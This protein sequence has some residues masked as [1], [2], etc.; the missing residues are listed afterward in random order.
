MTSFAELIRLDDESRRAVIDSMSA[1]AVRNMIRPESPFGLVPEDVAA[2]LVQV[3]AGRV[4]FEKQF[5]A[6][7][8]AFMEQEGFLEPEFLAPTAQA[9]P[10]ATPVLTGLGE[11]LQNIAQSGA[12]IVG[13]FADSLTKI[14]TSPDTAPAMFSE[15]DPSYVDDFVKEEFEKSADA[16]GRG[17]AG[18]F[19]QHTFGALAGGTGRIW[20]KLVAEGQVWMGKGIAAWTLHEMAGHENLISDLSRKNMEAVVGLSKDG[21]E[22]LTVGD[23]KLARELFKDAS[24][25]WPVAT[26]GLAEGM[27]AL[28]LDLMIPAPKIPFGATFRALERVPIAGAAARAA[29]RRVD[30]I[31]DLPTDQKV[32]RFGQNAERVLGHYYNTAASTVGEDEVARAIRVV[33]DL[34]NDKVPLKEALP[35]YLKRNPE[36]GT[37]QMLQ[38]TRE[39]RDHMGRIS[40]APYREVPIDGSQWSRTHVLQDAADHI[41]TDYAKSVGF[42]G[43]TPGE[44]GIARWASAQ[45][46][47]Q[48]GYAWLVM[49]MPGFAI[50][51]L[52]GGH[53]TIGMR[54]GARKV[55]GVFGSMKWADRA[56][57]GLGDS[58]ILY[59]TRARESGGMVARHIIGQDIRGLPKP[60]LS[61]LPVVGD[62]LLPLN[63]MS[64]GLRDQ[65]PKWIKDVPGLGGIGRKLI[66]GVESRQHKLVQQMELREA[67][68]HAFE[69]LVRK[70]TLPK[71][72]QDR[73]INKWWRGED[74]FDDNRTRELFSEMV[75]DF[76]DFRP[77][78]DNPLDALPRMHNS[79]SRE[80]VEGEVG[81]L[82]GLGRR[83]TDDEL[84]EAFERAAVRAEQDGIDAARNYY[85]EFPGEVGHQANEMLRAFRDE[86]VTPDK[87]TYEILGRALQHDLEVTVAERRVLDAIGVSMKSLD[88]PEGQ[89]RLL[90]EAM[91]QVE[92]RFDTI[93]K[94]RGQDIAKLSAR[95]VKDREVDALEAGR[96][97]ME[98]HND[99]IQTYA[100]R[101]GSV[102]DE[103]YVN[104]LQKRWRA[105]LKALPANIR[106]TLPGRLDESARARV[107]AARAALKR[108]DNNLRRVNA[109]FAKAA[110]AAR[111]K[112]VAARDRDLAALNRKRVE[113]TVAAYNDAAS[114]AGVELS[115]ATLR[116]PID[117]DE[118]VRILRQV[119]AER[120]DDALAPLL[121]QSFG[122]S[123]RNSGK[124]QAE[125]IRRATDAASANWNERVS[126][127][128]GL[129]DTADDVMKWRRQALTIGKDQAEKVSNEALF[130]YLYNR[131][132]TFLQTLF[133]YPY[134]GMK[135]A[136]MT[137]RHIMKKPGQ[138]HAFVWMMAEWLK[139]TEDLPWYLTWTVRVL[140][141]PDGSEV[142]FDP[143]T[144]VLPFG[145]NIAEIIN[146]G[147]EGE[148]GSNL[149]SMLFALNLWGISSVYPHYSLLME[150]ARKAMG[151]EKFE[152]LPPEVK[153]E[154]LGPFGMIPPME[155][156]M[157][158]LGGAHQRLLKQAAGAGNIPF[159]DPTIIYNNGLTSR[160][161]SVVGYVLAEM[162]EAGE[163]T[164]E[165]AMQ[166]SVD[167]RT[168]TFNPAAFEA[169]Q[170]YLERK[171]RFTGINILLGGFRDYPAAR[172]Q[173]DAVREQYRKLLDAGDREGA[174][175]LI[176][177][178]P[179]LPVRW[180]VWDDI[181]EAQK[182]VDEAKFWAEYDRVYGELNSE[183]GQLDV[184]D[185]AAREAMQAE[186]RERIDAASE[187]FGVDFET[188][189][190]RELKFADRARVVKDLVRSFRETIRAED[191]LDKDGVLLGE[192][193]GD[194]REQW[195]A[196][197]I[198]ATMQEEFQAELTKN[199]SLS[200]AILDTYQDVYLSGYFENTDGMEREEREEWIALNPPPSAL[201]LARAVQEAFPR[202]ELAD[203]H[204]KIEADNLSIEGYFDAS[205]Q[206]K[207]E[208]VRRSTSDAPYAFRSSGGRVVNRDNLPEYIEAYQQFSRWVDDSPRREHFSEQIERLNA[209]FSRSM[210][211]LSVREHLAG[212]GKPI[213]ARYHGDQAAGTM[214][215]VDLAHMQRE[216]ADLA[217]WTETVVKYY[218]SPQD[219][220][221][222]RED[223]LREIRRAY[224]AVN[225]TGF[226]TDD[227]S[228]AWR[229]FFAARETQLDNVMALPEAQ[230]MGINRRMFMQWLHKD[231]PPT[232]AVS[233]Y[234]YEASIRP[235]LDERAQI[236]EASGGRISRRQHDSLA[237]RYRARPTVREKVDE[238]LGA[239][240]HLTRAQL[241]PLLDEVLPSFAEYWELRGWS[242]PAVQRERSAL[243][244]VGG[245]GRRN[246]FAP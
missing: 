197:N 139:Q 10:E 68:S 79:I 229:E 198:P 87:R 146:A 136:T 21:L 46:K 188:D 202:F 205:T 72:L 209:E 215:L 62:S 222:L 33:E 196:H 109:D 25:G 168:V 91:D 29:R 18:G 71:N 143:K 106:K 101:F 225:P 43:A 57:E 4:A 35:E 231:S 178:H 173:A 207:I 61:Y 54:M 58:A 104:T 237:Y 174:N 8:L 160:E 69:T 36:L 77:A 210:A 17:D 30:W 131:G 194:A 5:G 195:R 118:Y 179:G 153:E 14:T 98:G 167:I 40:M 157:A 42:R 159:V 246:P 85:K 123:L 190:G 162:A 56:A 213:V 150:G 243:A 182:Q 224:Y 7:G 135:F 22:R 151:D 53:M 220:D 27:F 163:I 245:G 45:V 76:G 238:I 137:A 239:M 105:E 124:R 60:L 75:I 108:V 116:F 129:T 227:G 66:T 32:T 9:L 83:A 48:L 65:L 86:G 240:P 191:F 181:E 74:L 122:E 201:V 127:I 37:K 81:A 189:P 208:R 3:G 158:S 107:I 244:A 112:T 88:I 233:Q 23:T 70:S 115:E 28:P 38:M 165:V 218:T 99:L 51:N 138:F 185:M 102:A 120:G 34:A 180:I 133:P 132:E 172:R 20:E 235:A 212:Q 26:A 141:M 155:D 96:V 111:R 103:L 50:M 145:G 199:V 44:L 161:R 113:D 175:A 184:T 169:M 221:E 200:E 142:R 121:E 12:P 11:G 31:K 90:Q 223:A 49:R 63:L 59:G 94:G 80:M 52:L 226:V 16:L 164:P 130:S 230:K 214:G 15:P 1:Q 73:L 128:E 186:A 134:W 187:K 232:E 2:F 95:Y 206:A 156:A 39:T 125:S 64:K 6:K 193:Y 82:A 93:R 171:A 166:A 217:P 236:K 13:G 114:T 204:A 92:F 47:N 149:R 183:L 41:T 100:E 147:E 211:A 144:M 67:S 241:E 19:F 154:L 89:K 140:K 219:S 97:W 148:F 152:A 78:L 84:R 24:A 55:A 126:V 176:E 177:A 117:E 119:S 228:I 203:I 192:A 170:R 110:K 216:Q 242:A 234:W